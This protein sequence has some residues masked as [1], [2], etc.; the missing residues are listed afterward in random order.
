MGV[1]LWLSCCIGCL[2][3]G[4][5]GLVSGDILPGIVTILAGLA[6]FGIGMILIVYSDKRHPGIS[7]GSSAQVMTPSQYESYVAQAFSQQ[8]YTKVQVIGGTG[9]FG[10][11]VLCEDGDGKKVCIQCKKYAKPVGVAAVQEIIGAKG[12]YGC[13]R[14]MVVTTVGFTPAAQQLAAKNGVELYTLN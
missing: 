13:Q 2:V 7:P 14:A 9:D 11:D 1:I 8:G 4:I 12:F 3:G 5:A 6:L 10:A